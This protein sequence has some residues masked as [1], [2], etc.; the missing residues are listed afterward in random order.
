MSLT[1]PRRGARRHGRMPAVLAALTILLGA[2]SAGSSPSGS[3]PAPGA[4]QV[5]ATTTVLADLVRQVGGSR[6][7]VSSL[8]PKG[9][10]VHTFDPNPSD[11]QRLVRARLIVM[12]GL[13]LDDWLADLATKAGVSAPIVRLGED[14]AGVS[15]LTHDGQPAATGAATV[16]P[17]LWLDVAYAERYVAKLTAALKTAD[18]ADATAFDQGAAAYTARLADLDAW[19]RSTTGAIPAADRKVVSFHDAFP[20]YAAAYGLTVVGTVVEAPGQDP[21]AGQVAA[22]VRTIR[23]EGVKAILSEAQFSPALSKTIA[24]ETGATVVS[25]LYTDSLGDAPADTYEGIVRWD[26]ERLVAALR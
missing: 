24:D 12:N 14:L 26:T 7:D 22:L 1:G 4:I 15:Y 18:P 8:V 16:N 19:V 21:S 3:G 10:E 20:Y 5:V 9:G 11:A 13:G 23:D 2:C 6:V 17:H 25:D